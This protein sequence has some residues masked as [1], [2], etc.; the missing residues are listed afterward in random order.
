MDD[1]FDIIG[2]T[3][4]LGTPVYLVLQAASMYWLRNGWR[5]AA[6]VPLVFAVPIAI[7]CLAA[8]IAQSNL[9]PLTFILFAPI[10]TLYL[11]VLLALRAFRAAV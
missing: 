9:W 1:S 7:W 2:L 11:V 4:M 3:I 5:K 10:G 8:L 6:F